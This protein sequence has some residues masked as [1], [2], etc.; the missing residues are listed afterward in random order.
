[1]KIIA[2]EILDYNSLILG[3]LEIRRKIEARA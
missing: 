3:Y 1:M 2:Y